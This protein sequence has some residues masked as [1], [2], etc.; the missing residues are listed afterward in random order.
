MDVQSHV[1]GNYLFRFQ[2]LDGPDSVEDSRTALCYEWRKT[3][4]D[5]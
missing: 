1:H 5:K 2:I 4:I 3:D